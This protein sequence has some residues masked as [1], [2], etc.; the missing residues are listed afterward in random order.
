MS[1][2]MPAVVSAGHGDRRLSALRRFALAI[3]VLNILGH[4]VLGFE[5]SWA[6]PIVAVGAAYATELLLELVDARVN[7]RRVRF[8]G[9]PRHFVDFLL[10]AHIS[11]LAV[12]M[13]LYP[14]ARLAP[15]VFAAVVAI[16]SKAI[17]RVQVGSVRRHVF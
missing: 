14:N 11:G 8:A 4:T 15:V 2:T 6:H 3:T 10:S 13:L 17:L 9:S 5:Q 12:S 1:G 16:G 7:R